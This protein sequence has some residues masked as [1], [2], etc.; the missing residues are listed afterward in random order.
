MHVNKPRMHVMNVYTTAKSIYMRANLLRSR[1][2]RLRKHVNITYTAA[3]SLYVRVTNL[4][5]CV[6]ADYARVIGVRRRR[7]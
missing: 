5:A 2:K 7:S 4:C 1:V 6:K 3:K